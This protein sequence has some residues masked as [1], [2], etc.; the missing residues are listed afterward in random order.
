LADKG[1]GLLA[2]DKPLALSYE[3]MQKIFVAVKQDCGRLIMAWLGVSDA[4]IT[5]EEIADIA[6]QKHRATQA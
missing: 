6:I 1:A 3:T 5:P 2:V 4:P